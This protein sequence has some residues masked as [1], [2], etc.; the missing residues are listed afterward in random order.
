M[1]HLYANQA[2]NAAPT[3]DRTTA[4]AVLPSATMS[5]DATTPVFSSA[6]APDGCWVGALV[7]VGDD[8]LGAAD[9]E[10]VGDIVGGAE[11]AMVGAALGARVGVFEGCRGIEEQQQQHQK[12]QIAINGV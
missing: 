12:Q 4:A 8:A 9:G 1:K 2:S 11:G 10:A 5:V 6:C 7:K 3:M